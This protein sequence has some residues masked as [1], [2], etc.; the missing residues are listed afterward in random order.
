[1]DEPCPLCDAA[2]ERVLWRDARCRVILAPEPDFPGFCRAIWDAHVAELSDLADD[3]RA[4][5]L[6]V[7]LATER[8]LREVLAPDKV[9]LASLGNVVP[10]LHWHV[11]PRFR[12]D[13][14]F[15]GS[16]WS[17]RRREPPTRDV[18]ADALTAALER[19]LG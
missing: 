15:P 4:R 9:N 11:V 14:C 1:M 8:A 19:L 12:D 17:P 13:P 16:P 6:E 2:G 7:V 10:H 3:E 18:D 5:L